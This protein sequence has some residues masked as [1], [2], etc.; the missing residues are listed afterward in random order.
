MKKRLF[1]CFLIG[2][3]LLTGALVQNVNAP[4]LTLKIKTKRKGVK[5]F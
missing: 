3:M 4:E 5:H 1:G 2:S